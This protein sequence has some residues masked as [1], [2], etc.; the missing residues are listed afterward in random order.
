VKAILRRSKQGPAE[1]R[2]QF[3]LGDLR[4][5]PES[6]QVWLGQEKVHLTAT[7][8]K[9]LRELAESRG[10]VLSR[11][12]LLDRVWGY[13]FEGYGRTVDTHIRRLRK[14]LGPLEDLIET[15]RGIGYR[16]KSEGA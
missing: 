16:M 9:L 3:V 13:T 12:Q 1:E 4:I 7:E 8:F 5:D 14:K 15:V 11:E 6:H 10:R 2:R